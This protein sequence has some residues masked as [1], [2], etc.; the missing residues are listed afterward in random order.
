[1]SYLRFNIHGGTIYLR[2]AESRSG[3]FDLNMNLTNHPTKEGEKVL[4]LISESSIRGLISYLLGERKKVHSGHDS[5]PLF[6][7]LDREDVVNQAMANIR[8]NRAP[9]V[10][11]FFERRDSMF[12]KSDLVIAPIRSLHDY[13]W[14][15]AY[16]LIYLLKDNLTDVTGYQNLEGC[17]K[18]LSDAFTTAKK[19]VR[20]FMKIESK[21]SRIDK[22]NQILSE[23]NIKNFNQFKNTG[24]ITTINKILDEI[25]G[26]D[27]EGAP[28][29]ILF[30][31]LYVKFV[32]SIHDRASQDKEFLESLENC[33]SLKWSCITSPEHTR[34]WLQ[35]D[36]NTYVR[37]TIG[38]LINIDFSTYVENPSEQI[39]DRISKGPLIARW[40][41]SGVVEV[42]YHSTH[43]YIDDKDTLVN[44]TTVNELR[45]AGIKI[46]KQTWEKSITSP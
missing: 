31:S 22:Y 44:Y 38:Y 29:K 2:L 5:E 33:K 3:W 11:S 26:Y 13:I 7:D 25:N 20:D 1:M 46:T 39:V 28:N 37:G 17:R 21:E 24:I 36:Y 34:H 42:D 23:L 6:E 27:Y 10:T 14:E 12:N 8:I 45:R 9:F 16:P 32:N 19:Q 41:E 15:Q 4:S 35:D 18:C 30:C 40:G 43:P